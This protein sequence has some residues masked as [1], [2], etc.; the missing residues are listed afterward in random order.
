[1]L[2][3]EPVGKEEPTEEDRKKAKDKEIEDKLREAKRLLYNIVNLCDEILCN[4]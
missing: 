2:E 4:E 1:M 3:W